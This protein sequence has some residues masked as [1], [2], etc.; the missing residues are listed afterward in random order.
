M[1]HEFGE[2][3]DREIMNR[4][5][6]Q[7]EVARRGVVSASAIQ[8]VVAGITRPGPKVCRAIAKAFEMSPDEVFRL[9]GL[10]PIAGGPK[11]RERRRVVYEADTEELLLSLWRALSIED[12]ERIRDMM[13]RLARPAPRII[14]EEKT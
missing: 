7:S 10:L 9:A 5:W 4:G 3:L 8:Q 6:S 11:A 2:W 14:G 13:E 1:N 12:Q